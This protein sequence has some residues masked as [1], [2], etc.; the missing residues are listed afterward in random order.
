M[1]YKNTLAN[2]YHDECDGI[3]EGA[4]DR[5]DRIDAKRKQA[6]AWKE[7]HPGHRPR[8]YSW[9]AIAREQVARAA[10]PRFR[11]PRIA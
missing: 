8:R 5:E 2:L 7:R 6:T 4:A 9:R 10:R 3:T 11:E 1:T